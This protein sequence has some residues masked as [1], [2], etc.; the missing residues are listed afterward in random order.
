MKKKIT[1]KRLDTHQKTV[2][3][4]N[5]FGGGVT[6][7]KAYES[8]EDNVRVRSESNYS[9]FFGL[10]LSLESPKTHY[11]LFTQCYA[12]YYGSSVLR[13]VVDSMVEL[14][15]DGLDIYHSDQGINNFYRVWMDKVGLK[16]RCQQFAT[17]LFRECNVVL[18]RY[19][20]DLQPQ[21]I[22]QMKRD[23]KSIAENLNQPPKKKSKRIPIK[24]RFYQPR[25][26]EIVGDVA[27]AFSEKKIYGLRLNREYLLKLNNAKTTLE[28]QVLDDIPEVIKKSLK[29]NISERFIYYPLPE[30]DIYVSWYKKE[31][32][33][34]W[35]IPLIKPVLPD[36]VY[37]Q[38]LNAA[39]SFALDAY[40]H[41][42]RIWKLGDH[43]EGILPS[44]AVAN[45]LAGLLDNNTSA[46]PFDLIWDT[47][48]E[49]SEYYP[50]IEKLSQL[51]DDNTNIYL[52]FGFPEELIGG[53][54]KSMTGN[55]P[56]M[57][58]KSLVTKLAIVRDRLLE[59]LNF[60]INIIHNN[61]GFSDKPLVKFRIPNF[62]D[63]NV[64]VKVLMDLADRNIL[65]EDKVIE[66]LGE[67]PFLERLRI[68]KQEEKRD[69]DELPPKASPYH[70]PDLKYQQEHE[71]KVQK[72]NSKD[73]SSNMS[74]Q[75]SYNQRPGRPS[76]SKDKEPRKR[77]A[78]EIILA[79]N[80]YQEIEEKI[81]SIII[82]HYEVS[83]VKKL[84]QDQKDQ[85]ENLID[86]TFANASLNDSNDPEKIIASIN[87]DKYNKFNNIFRE[88]LSD[89]KTDKVSKE[90][91]DT[92]KIEAFLLSQGV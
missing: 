1:P 59:W 64:H 5:S 30:K 57:R 28:K 27:G 53:P 34:P 51:T 80:I 39:K 6:K 52:V 68:Q 49:Y 23:D 61:M 90:D 45:K 66:Y 40:A 78:S 92:L 81:T 17:H 9:D 22:A 83:N 55:N 82:E 16:E 46:G 88:L 25:N 50:P 76:G 7:T 2:A 8:I 60:E 18:Q 29:E 62:T 12:A 56:A 58:T 11:D 4:N 89:L 35:G 15:I 14:V 65:S 32:L 86:H 33:E 31:D 36:I 70:N 38:R 67:N 72:M 79:K 44:P 48:L 47:L 74:I 73:N 3:S 42:L 41:P 43:K 77:K 75:D 26:I 13:S 54:T 91:K 10:R 85:L 24:Y 69:K 21:D 20:V 37:N 19:Y 87:Y 84:T 71:L 63:D